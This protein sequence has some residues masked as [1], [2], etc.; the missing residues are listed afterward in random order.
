MESTISAT[1]L[2]KNLSDVLSRVRDRGERFVIQRDGQTIATI[3]PP[4][5][6][7]GIT[8]AELVARIGDLPIPDAGFADDLERIQ[9]EQ[10]PAEVFEWPG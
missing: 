8:V 5:G 10:G 3:I 6:P 1:Y 4:R 7:N 9:A 2:A